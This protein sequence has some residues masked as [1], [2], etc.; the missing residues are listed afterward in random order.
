MALAR[1]TPS[2]VSSQPGHPHLWLLAC[3]FFGVGDV[4]TTGIGIGIGGVAESN[5]LIAPLLQQ[6]GFTALGALKLG[7]L[8]G[9]YLVWRQLSR[10]H[11]VGI[12]LGLTFVGVLVTAWNFHIVI[13]ALGV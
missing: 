2:I 5:P 12:P 8:G 3:V 7:M 13:L 9:R 6:Y 4:V 1:P 11:C 10:P